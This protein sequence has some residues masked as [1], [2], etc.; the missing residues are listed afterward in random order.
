MRGYN[1]NYTQE[2]VHPSTPLLQ[3]TP[4]LELRINCSEDCGAYITKK[5]FM[6]GEH[7]AWGWVRTT[8][9]KC[10]EKNNG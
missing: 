3:R 6:M 4:D 1:E 5:E 2:R 8:C 9:P 7:T 10:V